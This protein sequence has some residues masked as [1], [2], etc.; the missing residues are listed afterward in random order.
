MIKLF[1]I[2]T[3]LT[4]SIFAMQV[5]PIKIY[6]NK[7]EKIQN[8]NITNNTTKTKTYQNTLY[9]WDVDINGK[10]IITP[11]TPIEIMSSP[12]IYTLKPNETKSLKIGKM[13]IKNDNPE[14]FRIIVKDI[15]PSKR[16]GVSIKMAS[17]IPIFVSQESSDKDKKLIKTKYTQTPE[18]II[19]EI[20]NKSNIFQEISE[21]TFN[22]KFN[23][24]IHY[25]LL[26][27]K[28]IKLKFDLNEKEKYK[29]YRLRFLN[30]IEIKKEIK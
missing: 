21:V 12:L 23:N 26:P 1:L 6:L 11:T 16:K 2:I 17:S 14:N 15:T 24:K 10:S 25:Y 20:E 13:I 3:F 30:G 28:K 18:Q 27:N 19:I 22:E 29:E 4:N 7:K 5:S 8:L 9:K